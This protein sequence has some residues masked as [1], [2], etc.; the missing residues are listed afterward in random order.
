ML[1][2]RHTIQMIGLI[3]RLL[4]KMLSKHFQYQHKKSDESF[5]LSDFLR[6]F[7]LII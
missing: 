6:T 3:L 7:V 4:E 2:S 1:T 5:G